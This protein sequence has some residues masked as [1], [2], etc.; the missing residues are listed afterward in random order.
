[1]VALNRLGG[2]REVRIWDESLLPGKEI[3]LSEDDVAGLWGH[4]RSSAP[5]LFSSLESIHGQMKQATKGDI[6]AVPDIREMGGATG[7]AEI[8]RLLACDKTSSLDKE[9]LERLLQA[10]GETLP[11]HK[12]NH[13][14]VKLLD[15]RDTLPKDLAPMVV[16]DASGRCR[17][18][19]SLMAGNRDNIVRLAPAVKSYGNLQV[20]LWAKGSGKYSYAQ[21]KDEVLVQGIAEK[22]ME[23][24]QEDWL[25]VHHK[26]DLPGFR[27]RIEAH[28]GEGV[29]GQ[30][31]LLSWGK[32]HGTN[33]YA[34]VS[35][36][37]LAS[38][39][40]LPDEVYETRVRLCAGMESTDDVSDAMRKEMALGE[41]LHNVLQALCRASVKGSAGR[42]DMPSLQ[43]LHH[44]SQGCGTSQRSL[45]TLPRVSA[46]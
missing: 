45:D 16:L 11:V 46:P 19:Y 8:D 37:I 34:H 30:L 43:G 28:L 6:L 23:R 36:V 39:L 31:H 21:D 41:H 14:E 1:M 2:P 5:K 3:L 9:R 32:H 12:T 22:I 26:N 25:I 20:G 17:E 29:T 35:N 13:G 10:A 18:T 33:A 40:H 38:L 44:R 7:S 15:Y 42:W 27:K 4:F 24:P